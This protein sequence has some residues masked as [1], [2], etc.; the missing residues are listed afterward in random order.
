MNIQHTVFALTILVVGLFSPNVNAQ[1]QDISKDF[2]VSQTRVQFD[3]INNNFFSYTNVKNNTTQS[4]TG[5][6]RAVIVSTNI[7]LIG[8]DGLTDNGLPFV[9]FTQQTLAAN[10]TIGHKINFEYQRTR[11]EYEVLIQQWHVAEVSRFD[12]VVPNATAETL[13]LFAA[14]QQT[15]NDQIMF[16][17]QHET[18]QGLSMDDFSGYESDTFNTV[19][20]FAA[21]VGWDTL[22]IIK[23]RDKNGNLISSEQ[24][25]FEHVRLA[26]QR[27][28][29][30]TISGHFDNKSYPRDG[31]Q[32]GTSWDNRV[33][34][35]HV[36][37][38]GK[39]HAAYKGDLDQ[40]ADWLN[41]MTV[42]ADDSTLIPIVLR[43]LHENTGSWFWWGKQ[44]C[45]PKE[46]KSLFRFTV[47][48]LRDVKQIRN[49]LIEYSP[50]EDA[51]VDEQTYLERYPGDDYVDV[52]GFDTYGA[53]ND[54]IW[55]N[56]VVQAAATVSKMARTRGKIAAIA[57]IGLSSQYISNEELDTDWYSTLLNA[58]KADQDAMNVSY[59]LVWRNGSY[60]HFWVPYVGPYNHGE[61]SSMATKIAESVL[62]FQAYYADPATL[63]NDDL[64]N[65]Y[66][67]ENIAAAIESPYAY[68]ISPT[69]YTAL[70]Q[71]GFI[72][73]GVGFEQPQSVIFTVGEQNIALTHAVT[74]G[75]YQGQLDTSSFIEDTLISGQMTVTF[76]NG[77]VWQQS[78]DFLYDQ[79]QPLAD[80]RLVD[81]FEGYFG[82]NELLLNTYNFTSG[83]SASAYLSAEHKSGGNYGLKFQYDLAEKGWTG[84]THNIQLPDSVVDWSE[85]NTLNMWLKPDNLS[86][87]LVIQI[88]TANGYWEAYKVL[89]ADAFIT[90]A[91]INPVHGDNSQIEQVIAPT[92]LEIPFSSF[93]RP[94]WDNSAGSIDVT[95]IKEVNFYINALA[96][97]TS[98]ETSVNIDNS[99]IYFDDIQ[100][101]YIQGNGD[102][103]NRAALEFDFEYSN[104]G[105]QGQIDWNGSTAV[106]PSLNWSQDGDR[107]LQGLVDLTTVTGAYVMQVFGE[108]D[109]SKLSSLS[110]YVNTINAGEAVKAK[111][112][113]KD[114]NW[115]W[116]DGGQVSLLPSGN[117]LDIDLS[118][119]DGLK[120][121]GVLF[122]G[123]DTTKTAAEFF[124]D[125]VRPIANNDNIQHVLYDF[126][127]T[128]NGWHG[129]I[130]W[131]GSTA[132]SLSSNWA[133]AGNK[134][135]QTVVD[136]SSGVN[137]FAMQ[138]F[139]DIDTSKMNTISL[140]VNTFNAGQNVRAKLF[141]KNQNWSWQDSGS[142]SVDSGGTTL[143]IDVSQL[144]VIKSI[145]VQFIDFDNTAQ[146][147]EFYVDDVN[148]N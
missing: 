108:F 109:V 110:L 32:N 55:L 114:N 86:Q 96:P 75:Y 69:R 52:L 127:T 17:H 120:S 37:P 41:A 128:L 10:G 47:E 111:L 88:K 79:N 48:Y 115:A 15:S 40:L 39:D 1:W 81:D 132:T 33:S 29:I 46:Y 97:D 34:V 104:H 117:R 123:F 106:I 133:A 16:G 4:I 51:G 143:T 23:H 147:A 67:L 58:L 112:F 144:D 19:G 28:S 24:D 80:I 27:G 43:L 121:V 31:G 45:T 116:S 59:M 2:A 68:I 119:L 142:V 14:M 61:S 145:G 21:V 134:A 90:T 54:N 136:I 113:V 12:L 122:Q 125:T 100:A 76:A 6:F 95:E 93:I 8:H 25:I 63:F 64:G 94:A 20:D 141:I 38:G 118:K 140:T 49:V 44:Q 72:Y 36:L 98:P 71:N 7:P 13:S 131:S 11:L 148:Y 3:R 42:S 89:G 103:S 77:R 18:T 146:A 129:Q 35:K 84:I 139:K 26:Y 138:V 92:W 5:P 105:W 78:V 73:V 57:E 83:D 66:H 60:N 9:L 74:S 22:S 30:I 126:E 62:D 135:A 137:S 124:I 53:P 130:N 91:Q 102:F 85:F 70:A 101:S 56:K 50:N 87:R 99:A 107:A 65:I 82:L